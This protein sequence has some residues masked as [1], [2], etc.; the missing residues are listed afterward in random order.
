MGARAAAA[1][2]L[3]PLPVAGLLYVALVQARILAA[4]PDALWPLA[5]FPIAALA[6]AIRGHARGLAAIALVELALLVPLHGVVTLARAWR[7]EGGG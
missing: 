6:L 2:L 7:L 3:V 1:W 5:A 4:R